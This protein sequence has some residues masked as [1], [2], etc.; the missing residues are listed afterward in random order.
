MQNLGLGFV[1]FRVFLVV[2]LKS[3]MSLMSEIWPNPSTHSRASPITGTIFSPH[4]IYSFS[5]PSLLPMPASSGVTKWDLP[6]E[7]FSRK[8]ISCP[9]QGNTGALNDSGTWRWVR[10]NHFLQLPSLHRKA[11]TIKWPFFFFC[12]IPFRKV[13][14]LIFLQ[15]SSLLP[16]VR[17]FHVAHP[18]A[19]TSTQGQSLRTSPSAHF[20]IEFHSQSLDLLTL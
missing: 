5:S 13:A 12:D 7:V 9:T 1:G 11:D 17:L 20:C 14:A 16:C 2:G 18:N 15:K 4:R 3:E 8:I 10:K 6:T 19:M